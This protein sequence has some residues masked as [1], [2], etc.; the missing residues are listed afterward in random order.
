MS[1][2]DKRLHGQKTNPVKEVT[3]LMQGQWVALAQH[4]TVGAA[5][6][7]QEKKPVGMTAEEVTCSLLA[8]VSHEHLS[9]MSPK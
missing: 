2:L 7:S 3:C 6:L 1:L 8:E 5:K 9:L 4:R